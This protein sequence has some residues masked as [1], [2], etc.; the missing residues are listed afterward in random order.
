[1]A[2][3]N[4]QLPDNSTQDINDSR[5][6]SADITAWNGKQDTL[7][8]GTNIKT[9]NNESLLGSGNISVTGQ[10]GEDGEDGV[11][12]A[13]VVQTTESTVS[14]GTNVITV[15]KTDGTS[16]TFNVRNGDAVGS[17][18]VVQSTGT[19]TDAV[20]SQDAVTRELAELDKRVPESFNGTVASYNSSQFPNMVPGPEG[21]LSFLIDF[22]YYA[23]LER[24]SKIFQLWDASEQNGF[25]LNIIGNNVQIAIKYNGTNYNKI[26]SSGIYAQMVFTFNFNTGEYKLYSNALLT[27]SGTYTA[28]S[29]PNPSTFTK[30]SL[31]NLYPDGHKYFAVFNYL[32]TQ[33][34]VDE[35][36][37]VYP[38]DIFPQ[39]YYGSTFNN[40]TNTDF[41]SATTN[42]TN[43][44][45]SER[46]STSIKVTTN[47]AAGGNPY[48]V[49]PNWTNL[50]EGKK[51]IKKYKMHLQVVSGG[52]T[53]RGMGP[54]GTIQELSIYDSNGNFLG[55]NT[56]AGEL[57]SGDYN[58]IYEG[59]LSQYWSAGV[60]QYMLMF[61]TTSSTVF[62]LSNFTQERLGAPLVF[63]PQNFRGTYWLMPGGSKIPIGSDLTVNYDTYKPNV[64]SVE[65]PQFNGQLK[66]DS[67][68]IYMGYLTKV[69]GTWKRIN[70][71]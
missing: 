20:M 34:D 47:G 44:S 5:I 27:A 64:T 17:V 6:G 61:G 12:I 57:P 38:Q 70:N 51:S 68:N 28:S 32:L 7:V 35:I 16:S 26:L 13:S 49:L 41:S 1:M 50:D 65:Y 4:I 39:K 22:R 43:V 60:M 55:K 21:V 45:Y 33:D 62:V 67:G 11:G 30:F 18:T 59:Q 54:Q 58:L 66:M 53:I 2:I 29:I 8:S 25:G 3:K 63:S 52:V 15:T 48:I 56:A 31:T 14:G 9:V 40:G 37:A 24:V 42:G 69:T 10:Q 36:F 19:A 71:A 46:T 23:T